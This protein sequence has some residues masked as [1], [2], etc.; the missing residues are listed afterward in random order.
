M[1]IM[2]TGGGELGARGERVELLGS[3]VL[4]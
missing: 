2:A 1:E 3:L 4:G